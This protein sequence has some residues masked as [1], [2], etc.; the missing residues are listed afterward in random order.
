MKKKLSN[1]FAIQKSKIIKKSV[2]KSSFHWLKTV[3][4]SRGN[5]SAGEF[6][7]DIPFKPKRY[8]VVTEVPSKK[9][10]GEH[11]H[12]KCHQ[13]LICIKGRMSIIVSDGKSNKE[14]L[15]D[16][17]SKGFYLP[18]LH[19]SIQRKASK[20]AI[21]LVFASHWYSEQDYIRDYDKF[22]QAIKK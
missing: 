12:W 18:P 15:L 13:F 20:D 8:F 16:S 11:A 19:W 9:L 7:K 10:R 22:L 6:L 2:G 3:V 17:V 4:D 1:N 14:F 21:L 5:L